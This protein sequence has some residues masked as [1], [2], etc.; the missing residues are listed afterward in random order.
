MI[1]TKKKGISAE[2][3]LVHKFWSAGWACVR[4]AGSGNSSFPSPDL[5]AGNHFL[6]VALECKTMNS[7][8]KYFE[9]NEI[10]QLLEFSKKFGAEPW[11]ALKFTRKSWIF[12]KV[13]HLNR[14]NTKWT[15]NQEIAHEKG[16]SFDQ[17]I[18]KN[19]KI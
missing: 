17:F 5:L 11:L 4:V 7:K 13:E 1:K 2:R 16:L 6:Q 18:L 15:I 10:L 14:T 12:V 8:Y 3:D 9:D 19:Q